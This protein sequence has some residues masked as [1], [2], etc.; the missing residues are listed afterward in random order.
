MSTAAVV[1]ATGNRPDIQVMAIGCLAHGLAHAPGWRWCCYTDRP[2]LY[3]MFAGQVDLL[4]PEPGELER[5]MGP[6]RFFFRLKYQALRRLAAHAPG[7]DLLYLDSDIAAAAGLEAVGDRVRQQPLMHAPETTLGAMRRRSQRALRAQLLGRTIADV[8]MTADVPMHNAGVVGLPAARAAG[9]IAAGEGLLDAM[10]ADGIAHFLAEQFAWSAA[11][12][13]A[14]A[15]IG[16]APEFRHYFSNKE[17]WQE[18]IAQRVAAWAG[19]QAPLT[20]LL[21]DLRQRPI[22]LPIGVRRR[23]WQRVLA[24]WAG[25]TR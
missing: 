16:S 5:G 21:D 11:L 2:E 1:L 19:T 4:V 18:A 8:A 22:A 7:H 9:L 15:G 23:K 17:A 13:A 14:G 6:Q 10:H 3:R 20:A 12:H 24:G 25:Y